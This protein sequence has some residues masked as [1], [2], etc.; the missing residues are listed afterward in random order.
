MEIIITIIGIFLGSV[1]AIYA[2]YYPIK[3]SKKLTVSFLKPNDT[4]RIQKSIDL[5]CEK[6]A[7]EQRIPPDHLI[8]SLTLKSSAI[9]ERDF[10]KKV[11]GNYNTIHL[12]LIAEF[13]GEI[14]GLLKAIYVKDLKYMFIAYLISKSANNLDSTRITTALLN[15]FYNCVKSISDIK[16]IAFEIVEETDNKHIAKEKLFKHISRAKNFK[17][18]CINALY[19]IPEVCSFD[20]GQ[21]NIFKSRLYYLDLKENRECLS[22]SEYYNIVKSIYDNIYTESYRVSEPDLVI[23]HTKFTKTIIQQIKKDGCGKTRI[24]LL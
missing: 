12:P 11:K 3:Y 24:E 8:K 1:I 17:A 2:I 20:E 22:K 7:N 18:K 9:T 15:K 21:C 19:L 14:I 5:Y 13:Q 23:Q 4:E 10:K 16:F 6:I